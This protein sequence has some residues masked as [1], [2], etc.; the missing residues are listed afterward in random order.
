MKETN[1]L[2]LIYPLNVTSETQANVRP[3][4][5]LFFSN[6]EKAEEMIAR[7][8]EH[9]A[10]LYNE[11]TQGE[12]VYCLIMEEYEMDSPFRYQLSTRVYTSDGKLINDCIIPD[13]GPFLGRPQSKIQHQIG[14][15]VELP[16]GEQLLFGIVVRQPVCICEDNIPY[17]LSASD[18]CYTIIQHPDLEINYAHSPMVFKPTREIS[19]E[20]RSTLS[21]ALNAYQI[22]ISA[23]P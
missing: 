15:V 19:E 12:H 5:P 1:A 9:Y 21:E 3:G 20:V 10:F 17:G 4:K 8:K 11:E 6:K 18:D 22:R 14:D 23:E 13:D 2:F 16:C 7:F